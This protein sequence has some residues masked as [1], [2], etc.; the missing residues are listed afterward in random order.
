MN[1]RQGAILQVEGL[2]MAKNLAQGGKWHVR[3]V[4]HGPGN[5]SLKWRLRRWTDSS[6]S[7]QI[8]VEATV[9]SVLS[10]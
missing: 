8:P 2:V 5:G 3:Y 6:V 1:S 10:L 9:S 7:A 4:T